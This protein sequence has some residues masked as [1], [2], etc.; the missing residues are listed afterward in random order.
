M[1]KP[2]GFPIEYLLTLTN[3]PEM[4][5]LISVFTDENWLTRNKSQY[6]KP[7]CFVIQA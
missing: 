7:L 6:V 3:I 5:L 1:S 4:L 2:L